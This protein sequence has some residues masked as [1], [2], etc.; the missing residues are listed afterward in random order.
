MK[1]PLL[2]LAIALVPSLAWAQGAV[3]Q[4]GP[5]IK[6]DL[7]GWVQ[8]KT[9][10]SGG[11]M[12][13]DNFRGFNP[14][15]FFDNRGPGV[16]TE[17]ALT[18]PGPYNQLCFGHNAN[19]QGLITTNGTGS[20]VFNTNGVVNFPFSP[21]VPTPAPGDNS[22]SVATTAFV[23]SQIGAAGVAAIPVVVNNTALAALNTAT[24]TRA[25]RL[26]YA[27]Q[28]DQS[29][30]LIFSLEIGT[31]AANGR[32]NDGGS[33][34]NSTFDTNS[35][36]A[37]LPPTG[38]DPRWFG[39]KADGSTDCQ[40]AIQAAVN[41]GKP[42]YIAPPDNTKSLFTSQGA[43][44]GTNVLTFASVP[45][46]IVP[47]MSVTDN[48]WS[49]HLPL[50]VSV[51]STTA[52]TV[53]LTQSIING[54]V[55]LGEQF[56]FAMPYLVGS[57]IVI[58]SNTVIQGGA[59]ESSI[60]KL[61]ASACTDVIQGLNAY[62]LFGA[63]GASNGYNQAHGTSFG[64]AQNWRLSDFTIDGNYDN[65]A[66]CAS[67]DAVNGIAVY[68]AGWWITRL[69]IINVR[70]HGMRTE[71]VN[72]SGE[73]IHGTEPHVH[74]VDINRTGR[75]NW[76][77]KGPHDCDC[78]TLIFGDASQEVDNTYDGVAQLGGLN[79]SGG[80]WHNFHAY[81]YSEA[82]NRARFQFNS[83][84]FNQFSGSTFEGGRHQYHLQPGAA[85]VQVGTETYS[86]QFQPAGSAEWVLESTL[87]ACSGCSWFGSPGANLYAIQFG[88]SGASATLG[89]Q[90]NNS[91]PYN[92][93]TGSVFTNFDIVT[94]FNF[95]NGG[96]NISINAVGWTANS[97][98]TLFSGVIDPTDDIQYEQAGGALIT[99]S[100][101]YTPTIAGGSTAGAPTYVS[102]VGSVQ[103]NGRAIQAH[104]NI[105]ISAQGGMVGQ[106]VISLPY[107]ASVIG[108]DNGTC[109]FDFISGVTLAGG[110]QLLGLISPGTSNMLLY[111]W[112]SGGT[113]TGVNVTELGS[114]VVIE[115]TC[116][117]HN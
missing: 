82:T 80:V 95:A 68:G 12:F 76:W 61:K 18:S 27:A 31:C 55:A 64:G 71:W 101:S 111:K 26:G 21:T 78:N 74:A 3:L 1:K 37:L 53:T 66:G 94:P 24:I 39:C 96:P 20:M 8:D 107:A 62:S 15:H 73:L 34:V 32:V 91:A 42:V 105:N 22:T 106:P 110:G 115:G 46:T 113:T 50:G 9:I 5:V 40:P 116:F 57:P 52:T 67:P 30:P 49:A 65:N 77:D 70:G 90:G 112:I 10:M 85:D 58:S 89:C 114:A 108:N 88:C 72:G 13:T 100:K 2:A 104:F 79:V 45:S 69:A 81:H 63:T 11:K 44:I 59:R 60:L 38:V 33:C 7:P 19:G 84:G 92:T 47:G 6:F 28:G 99:R 93:I 43:N 16:C 98:A 103:K 102:A 117:Y 35:W 48:T 109:A 56:T 41:L 75:H 86:G 23:N 87:S 83:S 36:Y 25:L 97:G 17:D 14:A 51:A 29:P 4:N 54:V